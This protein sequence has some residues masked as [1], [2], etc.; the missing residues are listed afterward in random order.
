MLAGPQDLGCYRFAGLWAHLTS[1]D[2][3]PMYNIAAQHGPTVKLKQ[4][5]HIAA[6]AAIAAPF[7]GSETWTI[8]LTHRSF[9]NSYFDKSFV[10]DHFTAIN[11]QN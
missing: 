8:D 5:G 11:K 6:E 7:L 4:M 1:D 3:S 2:H 9:R 10:P